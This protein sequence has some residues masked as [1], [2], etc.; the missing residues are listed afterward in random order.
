MPAA[1]P[2]NSESAARPL[3]SQ[4]LLV[5]VLRTFFGSSADNIGADPVRGPPSHG[6]SA[7][8]KQEAAHVTVG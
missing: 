2:R 6:R 7:H 1:A 8:A 3:R 4:L 5:I